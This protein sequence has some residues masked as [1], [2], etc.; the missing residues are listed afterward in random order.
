MIDKKIE[1]RN[2][3]ITSPLWMYKDEVVFEEEMAVAELLADEVL[4]IGGFTRSDGD[5][6]PAQLLV[7][8]NDVWMWGC[9]D[10]EVLPMNEIRSLYEM[11]GED[12]K[13]GSTWWC[14]KQRNMQ[15]Q[16]PMRDDMIKEK[17][18]PEWMHNLEVNY[19]QQK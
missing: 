11:W 8:A 1:T 4:L 2:I 10:A 13:W 15:P 18:Y 17:A 5:L 7:I 16:K 12:K 9:A 3:E 6:R 14:C 19:D